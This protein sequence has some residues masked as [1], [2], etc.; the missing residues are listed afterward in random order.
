LGARAH[1][2]VIGSYITVAAW[3]GVRAVFERF[4]DDRLTFVILIQDLDQ[5]A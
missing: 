1:T 5:R 4:V 2:N 3:P